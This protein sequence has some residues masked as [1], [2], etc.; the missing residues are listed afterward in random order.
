[1]FREQRVAGFD[2]S[3]GPRQEENKW[4]KMQTPLEL[5]KTPHHS[6]C[7][8]LLIK[9]YIMLKGCGFNK[10]FKLIVY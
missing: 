1:M 10:Y 7:A 3:K 8:L 2:R 9:E 6:D 5:Q 4:F